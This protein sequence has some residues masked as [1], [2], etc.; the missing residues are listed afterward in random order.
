MLWELTLLA[1]FSLCWI[2]VFAA[3]VGWVS[4]AGTLSLGLYPLYSFAAALGWIAG[5]VFLWRARTGV[6]SGVRKRLLLSYFIGP[7]SF[8]FALRALASE[9]IQQAAP[10]VPIYGFAVYAL[11]FL[12]PLTLRTR[13]RPRRTPRDP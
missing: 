2:L 5:N 7:P 12:V 10:L 6:S 8:L 13:R 11:F 4:L 3:G 1:A 9:E